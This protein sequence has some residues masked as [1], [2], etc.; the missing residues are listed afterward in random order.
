MPGLLVSV[1]SADEAR[2]A[3]A[4]GASVIDVKE[5]RRGPLGRAS[6]EVVRQVREAVPSAIPVSM[7]LGEI[8]EAE[9][10]SIAESV[11]NLSFRKLGLAGADPDWETQWAALRRNHAEGPPWVA[12][13][14]TDWETACSPPPEAIVQAA[15]GSPE[16]VGLLVDTWEKSRPGTLRNSPEWRDRF[17]RVQDTGRFVALAGRLNRD[18]ILNLAP[19]RPNLFA[20]RGAACRAGDRNGCVD[21]EQVAILTRTVADLEGPCF[22]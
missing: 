13:V 2:A 3:V 9:A 21:E 5:P 18:T 6:S 14:Y 7:A 4:G 8:H 19:L 17:A 12:V 11:A 22:P 1:R 15:L 16:V 10:T 20:V